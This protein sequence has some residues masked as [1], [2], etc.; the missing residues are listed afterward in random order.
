MILSAA[1][2]IIRLERETG[3]T[4]IETVKAKNGLPVARRDGRFLDSS[5]DPHAGAVKRLT[6]LQTSGRTLALVFGDGFG[7]LSR[8]LVSLGMDVL[9]VESDSQ[10]VQAGYEALGAE[11]WND[12]SLV[13]CPPTCEP[14]FWDAL[15]PDHLQASDILVV[16]PLFSGD[17]ALLAAAESFVICLRRRMVNLETTGWFGARW[18]CNI[19]DTLAHLVS[20]EAHIWSPS[21]LP[22]GGDW[23][24]AVPGPSLEESLEFL[25]T[26]RKHYTL[27]ALAPAVRT[28]RA[29]GISPDAVCTSDGGWANRLHLAGLG[30]DQVPLV[31]PLYAAAGI[32]RDWPGPLIPLSCGTG[33]ETSLVT[34]LPVMGE[35]PTVALL[36]LRIALAARADRI[37][38]AGQDFAARSNKGHARGYRFDEDGAL[39]ALRTRPTEK[40]LD[41]TWQRHDLTRAGWRA[42]TKSLLYRDGLVEFARQHDFSL[43][44]L[45]DSPFLAEVPALD[46]FAGPGQAGQAGTGDLRLNQETVR[47]WYQR[48]SSFLDKDFSGGTVINPTR[49]LSASPFEAFPEG[50]IR[51][52]LEDAVLYPLFE[53]GQPKAMRALRLGKPLG[54]SISGLIPWLVRVRRRL[55]ILLNNPGSNTDR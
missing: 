31:L 20:L 16:P 30:L 37:I 55:G 29:A 36:A 5:H 24:I 10:L 48:I 53:L 45:G 40:A 39:R 43:L 47:A 38:L 1:E 2:V 54:Q 33:I 27:L 13:L 52:I 26:Q 21:M 49:P 3:R 17:K 12:F 19:L 25:S 6:G 34:G 44:R 14:S 50:E 51:E 32:A 23:V 4:R 8:H 35:T 28:L 18:V 42:D 9:L 11:A 15:L 46:A 7:Y 41:A 22:L